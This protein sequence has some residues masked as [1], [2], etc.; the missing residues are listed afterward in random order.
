MV[1]DVRVHR[2]VCQFVAGEDVR[3]GRLLSVVDGVAVMSAGTSAFL[4]I[5]QADA[6][7]GEIVDILV[8]GSGEFSPPG[9]RQGSSILAKAHALLSSFE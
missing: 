7:S 5:A 3:M 9:I 2:P 8:V 6:K 1:A 4:G